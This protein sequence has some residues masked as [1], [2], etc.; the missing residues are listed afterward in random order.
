MI[1]FLYTVY[2]DDRKIGVF[3]GSCNEFL[4][5]LT[6]VNL[7]LNNVSQIY[8]GQKLCDT[9]VFNKILSKK[10]IQL[11][12]RPEKSIMDERGIFLTHEDC[13]D[14]KDRLMPQVFI[15]DDL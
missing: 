9:E 11:S 15:E 13:V 1:K 8:F 2:L 14:P 5:I 12:A 3:K 4:S 7:N 6:S 10:G